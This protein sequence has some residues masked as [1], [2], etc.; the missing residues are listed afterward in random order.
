MPS[1]IQQRMALDRQRTQARWMLIWG[2]AS[3]VSTAT[4]LITHASWFAALGVFCAVAIIA[5]GAAS[6]L[7]ARR[8]RIAFETAHGPDAGKQDPVR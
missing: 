1:L 2:C 6:F 7:T 4:L 8:N 5:T 3:T